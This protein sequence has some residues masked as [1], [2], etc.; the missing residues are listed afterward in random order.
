MS[1]SKLRELVMD[2]EACCAAVHGV[3]KSRTWLSDWTERNWFLLC[4]YIHLYHFSRFHIYVLTYDICFFSVWLL[5]VTVYVQPHFK[6]SLTLLEFPWWLRFFPWKRVFLQWGRPRF[7]PWVRKIFWRKESQPTPIFLPGEF[8]RQR[9]LEGYI[10]WGHKESDKTERL[11]LSLL[12]S[13]F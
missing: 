5:Y 1:L 10:L 12:F 8:H 13:L 9:S 2:R 11:T 4:K 3:T 7:D 6:P